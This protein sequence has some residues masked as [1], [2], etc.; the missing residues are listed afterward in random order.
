LWKSPAEKIRVVVIR[1]P[2]ISNS[3]DFESLALEPDVA[4]Q[5]VESPSQV[6]GDPDVVIIPGTKSTVADLGFLRASGLAAWLHRLR[7]AAVPIIGI[8]GGFQMMGT[9]ILDP[10]NVEAD[11]PLTEG[12]GLLPVS[13]TFSKEKRTVRVEG[14]SLLFGQRISGYEIHMGNMETSETPRPMFQITQESGLGVNRYDG[15][16]SADGLVWGTYIHGLFNSAS[17][18]RE[19]LNRLREN[20][21]WPPLLPD[22]GASIKSQFEAL[23]AL[24]NEHLDCGLLKQILHR[25]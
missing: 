7:A 22:N 2:R 9:Q 24:V 4:L 10:S 17:F 18:S 5:Y 19:F 6:A 23:S 3:T 15:C 14:I 8:C 21:G 25:Q 20:R 13:T 11:D 1:L 12:L 16:I